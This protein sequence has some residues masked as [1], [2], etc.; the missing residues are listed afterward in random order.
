[1]THHMAAFQTQ[2]HQKGKEGGSGEAPPRPPLLE[3]CEGKGPEMG[4]HFL[5]Y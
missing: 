3:T 2:G 4:S 5:S 1:M